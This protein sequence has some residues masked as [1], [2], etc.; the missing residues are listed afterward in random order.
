[1]QEEMN[2][3]VYPNPTKKDI[4]LNFGK[5]YQEANIQVRNLTGQIILNKII[6]NNSIATLVLEGA[7]GVYFVSI[8]TTEGRG[9]LK[10][11]KE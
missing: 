3:N 6:K 4:T 5:T 8:Q 9:I 2:L 1:M 7:A 11:I 10:I